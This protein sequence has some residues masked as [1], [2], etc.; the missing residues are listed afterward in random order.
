MDTIGELPESDGWRDH[1]RHGQS[2]FCVV[3]FVCPERDRL[4]RKALGVLESRG[5]KDV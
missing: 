4:K 5:G 1:G 3:N 2:D